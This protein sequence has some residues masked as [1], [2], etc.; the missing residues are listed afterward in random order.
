MEKINKVAMEKP[1]A[2]DLAT[3]MEMF[4]QLKNQLETSTSSGKKLSRRFQQVKS[5]AKSCET[6]VKQLLRQVREL[7]VKNDLMSGVIQNLIQKVEENE[8]RIEKV[9]WNSMKRSVVLTGFYADKGRMKAMKQVQDFV[10]S[11]I[12]ELADVV[13]IYPLG[14]EAPQPLVVTFRNIDQELQVMRRK[15]NIKHLINEDGKPF[16]INDY[17]PAKMSEQ[18]RREKDIHW[19]NSR[20]EQKNQVDMEVK[21][22]SL[23]IEGKKY[24]KKVVE[25]NPK[26]LLQMPAVEVDRLMKLQIFK[27]DNFMEQEN[28]FVGYTA[29]VKSHV[30]ISDMY[31]KV[32][33]LQPGAR[34]IVCAYAL[35]GGNKFENEDYCDDQETGVGRMLLKTMT[36]NKIAQ[37]V[38]LVV[39]YI[40][41]EKLGSIRFSC[42]LETLK[43]A[44]EAAPY[45]ELTRRNETIKEQEK[46]VRPT[47]NWCCYRTTEAAT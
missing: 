1:G 26:Q 11:E 14:G 7:Q 18:R 21:S 10:N 17:L 9:E 33:L 43:K 19:E 37:R 24:E 8:G 45:N 42:Y 5:A 34:H 6:N 38:V 41:P 46:S 16:F 12:D 25:P 32:R 44:V 13:D 27:T 3:V 20:A 40:G 4:N 23:W 35:K 28:I 30:E 39:R 29:F 22:G 15:K 2:I 31:M 36:D 47:R